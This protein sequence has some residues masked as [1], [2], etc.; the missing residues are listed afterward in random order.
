MNELFCLPLER[1]PISGETCTL[2]LE[3]LSLFIR[4][5]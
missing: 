3:T 1:K 5:V 2:T 4:C